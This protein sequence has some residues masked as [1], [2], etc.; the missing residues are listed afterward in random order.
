MDLKRFNELKRVG[1]AIGPSSL[2]VGA[3]LALHAQPYGTG[4]ALGLAIVGLGSAY[5][6]FEKGFRAAWGIAAGLAYA[7][8]VTYFGASLETLLAWGAASA[9]GLGL[10]L[11][12]E[13]ET[14]NHDLD[15]RLKLQK[16]ETGT[17]R[18]E[19]AMMRL[20]HQLSPT[21]E[22]ILMGNTEQ[23]TMLRTAVWQLFKQELPGCYVE[24]T[25]RGWK[26]LVQLPPG[27]DRAK[28]RTNWQRVAG[29]LA[30]TGKYSLED[31]EAD[32]E[33][34]VK[35]ATEAMFPE[36]IPYV[37]TPITET[38]DPV[39]L[40]IDEDGEATFMR[41]V[42]RHTLVLGTSG[43]GKSNISNK[44]ILGAVE[45]GFAVIG[46]DMKKGI[47]LAAVADLLVT[48]AKDGQG[49]RDVFDWLDAETDRRAEIMIREGIRMWSDEFGPN[50][51]LVVDELSELT[52]K[53]YKIEGLPTLAELNAS[54]TR[55]MRAFGVFMIAATQAPSAGAFGGNTDARTNYKN[56]I[57]TGLMEAHHARFAFGESWKS[58]GWD[59]NEVLRGPGEFMLSNDEH[60]VPKAHKAPYLTDRDIASEVARL[61]PFKVGLDGSPWGEGGVPITVDTRVLNLLRNRGD[62]AMKDIEGGLSLSRQQAKDAIKRLRARKGFEIEYDSVEQVYRM[63]TDGARG[64]VPI[65]GLLE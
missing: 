57:S 36:T 45:R 28:F 4:A 31:G 58:K 20:Q 21:P 47:E 18:Q 19:M 53:K 41:F 46:I 52:D 9:A 65:A 29:A 44:L 51:L 6:A 60:R 39:Y 34:W 55:I 23:E 50:I 35:Y 61:L 11:W 49:A 12:F 40:G 13:H 10:R 37:V 24:P 33:I 38:S 7:A 54:A 5:V 2:I 62:L 22:P 25:P 17:I 59:P 30:Q 56:R 14:R 32:N 27:L 26:A 3:G 1:Y 15:R 43:N 42:E 48:V 64:Q 16:Y 8:L 63:A